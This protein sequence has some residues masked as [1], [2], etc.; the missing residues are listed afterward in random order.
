MLVNWCTTCLNV[1]QV[2]ITSHHQLHLQHDCQLLLGSAMVMLASNSSS[3]LRAEHSKIVCWSSAH[4]ASLLL[5]FEAPVM[6]LLPGIRHHPYHSTIPSISLVE[7]VPPV[8]NTGVKSQ[9]ESETYFTY[10]KLYAKKVRRSIFRWE[11]KTF[12]NTVQF[13]FL[14]ML[15]HS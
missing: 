11:H 2:I 5:L 8:E 10:F 12:F 3:R 6:V 13:H 7:H 4:W 15:I 9:N 1:L 14:W